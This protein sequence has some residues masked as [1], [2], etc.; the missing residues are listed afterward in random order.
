MKKKPLT[1]FLSLLTLALL[2][3][4][5]ITQES[6]VNWKSALLDSSVMAGQVQV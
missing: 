5:F 2:L 1:I 4:N 3:Y 6:M